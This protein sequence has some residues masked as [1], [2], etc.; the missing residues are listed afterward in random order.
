M[1]DR[2]DLCLK[3]T[4]P[5]R[6]ASGAR[7]GAGLRPRPFFR[8]VMEVSIGPVGADR[9]VGPNIVLRGTRPQADTQ[10]RPYAGEGRF[11]QPPGPAAHSVAFAPA[12]GRNEEESEQRLPQKCPATPDNPS[13]TAAP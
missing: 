8:G 6:E 11:P 13:V 5:L 1:S 12:D 3:H 7:V 9:C 10:V 4:V 2:Q